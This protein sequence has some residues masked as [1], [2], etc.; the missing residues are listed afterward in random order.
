MTATTF[1]IMLVG[2]VLAKIALFKAG[3]AKDI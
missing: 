1:I 3:E 2:P